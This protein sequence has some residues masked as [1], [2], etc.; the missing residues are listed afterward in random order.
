[1]PHTTTTTPR[2]VAS[3]L[4]TST[5]SDKTSSPSEPL[6]QAA[7]K[8]LPSVVSIQF[9]SDQEAGSGSGVIISSD[10]DILTN[11]H[12]VAAVADGGGSLQV[13]FSNGKTGRGSILAPGPAPHLGG[14]QAKG[15]AGRKP[16]PI[17]H[18]RRRH[19][20]RT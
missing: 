1:L 6:S 11:N 10:G 12:V 18:A 8:V 20:T 16:R 7:A 5:A 17:G 9:Q 13:P 4:A 2:P 3:S 14:R 19:T 15:G